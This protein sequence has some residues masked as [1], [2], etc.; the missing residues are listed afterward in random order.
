VW[1]LGIDA[2]LSAAPE[3]GFSRRDRV[4]VAPVEHEAARFER[5]TAAVAGFSAGKHAQRDGNLAMPIWAAEAIPAL[6]S[7]F[8]PV[9]GRPDLALGR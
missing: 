6:S 1:L 5:G 9:S 2:L 8:L 4:K 7:R 3:I